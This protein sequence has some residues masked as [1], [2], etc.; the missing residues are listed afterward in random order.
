[1]KL[2]L[3]KRFGI[4][5]FFLELQEKKI[6]AYIL[7]TAKIVICITLNLVKHMRLYKIMKGVYY[8]EMDQS[9]FQVVGK[10]LS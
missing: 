3:L 5:A 7:I 10:F 9:V 2:L 1:M 4:K 8:N 6:I